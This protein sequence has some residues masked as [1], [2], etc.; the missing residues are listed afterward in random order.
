MTPDEYEYMLAR[1]LIYMSL[2]EGL[3]YPEGL[4][5]ARL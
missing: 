2:V 5:K 4:L 1:V 3:I